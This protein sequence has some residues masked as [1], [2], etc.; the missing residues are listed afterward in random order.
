MPSDTV[1]PPSF[2]VLVL[3]CTRT[4]GYSTLPC[5]ATLLHQHHLHHQQHRNLHQQQR[6]QQQQP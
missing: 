3:H 1:R 6:Q 4:A 2:T 5:A